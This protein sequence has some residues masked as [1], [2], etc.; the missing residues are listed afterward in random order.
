MCLVLGLFKGRTTLVI[1]HRM[2][3]VRKADK[4]VVFGRSGC[5]VESGTHEELL[6]K[7]DKQELV[8]KEGGGHQQQENPQG[9]LAALADR[10]LTYRDLVSMQQGR[11]NL[12]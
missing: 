2:A 1:A 12:E 6:A 10:A 3:T 7:E 5:V 11:G 9:S 8:I 4:I